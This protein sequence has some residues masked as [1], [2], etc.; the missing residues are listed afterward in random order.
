MF[1]LFKKN[2]VKKEPPSEKIEI[3]VRY[4]YEWNA[5]VPENERDTPEHPSRPFCKKLMESNRLY[6]RK[7]IEDIS[8]RLGYSVWNRKGGDGCRHT[9][10]SQTV[11]KKKE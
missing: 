2:K 7:E 6:T 10:V 4:S 8:Q 5:D 9:W 11:V 3:N 1:N